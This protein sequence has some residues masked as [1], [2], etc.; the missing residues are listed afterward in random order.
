MTD[1]VGLSRY[2]ESA[3]AVTPLTLI[4]ILGLGEL[5]LCW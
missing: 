2:L 4:A 5:T 3:G 1:V